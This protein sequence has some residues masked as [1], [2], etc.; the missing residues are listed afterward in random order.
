M[1]SRRSSATRADSRASSH[2]LSS[3]SAALAV[4]GCAWPVAVAVG[5]G[6]S[7]AVAAAV[8]VLV[9][10][11]MG[12]VLVG[13][14]S[15]WLVVVGLFLLFGFASVVGVNILTKVSLL[16]RFRG[17]CD[18]FFWVVVGLVRLVYLRLR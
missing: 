15:V 16:L 9:V 1:A 8:A 5:V 3:L 11:G 13:L 18:V 12:S 7:G 6:A 4:V 10:L 2:W 17:C 14:V